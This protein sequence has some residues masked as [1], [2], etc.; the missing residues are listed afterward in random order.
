MPGSD[1]THIMLRLLKRIR[2]CYRHRVLVFRS[3]PIVFVIVLV[4][5]LI[6][7]LHFMSTK[8]DDNHT[9]K[10]KFVLRTTESI[11]QKTQEVCVH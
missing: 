6:S 11:E 4:I 7:Y 9:N 2:W 1:H 5:V 10:S 8:V 3:L